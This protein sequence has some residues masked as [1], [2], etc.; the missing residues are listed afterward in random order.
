MFEPLRR[1]SSFNLRL[2]AAG[3]RLIEADDVD[4]WSPL[5]LIPPADAHA[6]LP[7]MVAAV[8]ADELPE[9]RHQAADFHAACA[10]Q[11]HGGVGHLAVPGTNHFDVLDGFID[12]EGPL[13]AAACSL[14]GV[15]PPKHIDKLALVC[16]R[17]RKLLV[18]R[19]KGKDTF[20]APGGKRDKGE[21]DVQALTRE[22]REELTVALKEASVAPYGVFRAQAHG[23][24]EGT[25]VVMTC[26][27]A[28]FDGELKPA[29]E[30]E[31]L[32]WVGSEEVGCVSATSALIVADLKGKELID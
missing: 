14:L 31:E 2:A 22:C 1:H 8:G 7:P 18:A 25:N 29:S 19:S 6:A 11:G 15:A 10:A 9:L 26:Y 12:G 27:T 32:R 20:Y 16:V 30:I 24:P 13:F 5:A 21:S 23:K 28:D 4:E 3:R 17:E